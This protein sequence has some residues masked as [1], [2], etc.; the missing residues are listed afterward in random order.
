MPRTISARASIRERAT[1]S[2]DIAPGNPPPFEG[3]NT[4]HYSVVDRF[5]NA[6]ANTYTLNFSYGVG[7][8]RRRHRRAAQQRAR[9]FRRQARRAQRLWPGRPQRGQRAGPEQAA[10]VVDDARPSCSRTASRCWSPA[11]P[12]AAASSPRC[13]RSIVNVVDHRMTIAD[14]VRAPRIHHQWLPDEVWVEPGL[15]PQVLKALEARGH[16]MVPRIWGTSAN[17]IAIW[18]KASPARPTRARAAHWR[19]VIERPDAQHLHCFIGA[20]SSLSDH[21]NRIFPSTVTGT[22]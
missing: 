1:P 20:V 15:P 12:A 13:C 17:S 22:E 18:R 9:R 19:P 3:D 4:T 14:A 21:S 6:V 16:K 10:A 8:G 11:R 7:P 5:G 2:R